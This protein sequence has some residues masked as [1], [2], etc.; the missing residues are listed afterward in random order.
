MLK[1]T[2]KILFHHFAQGSHS[3][4]VQTQIS[5]AFFKLACTMC[6]IWKMYLH[7]LSFNVCHLTPYARCTE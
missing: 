1:I 3:V 4:S 7:M 5:Q 6:Q 2:H